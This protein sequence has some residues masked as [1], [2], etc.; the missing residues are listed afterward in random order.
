MRCL[1]PECS[2][3]ITVAEARAWISEPPSSGNAGINDPAKIFVSPGPVEIISVEHSGHAVVFAG[4]RSRIL[5]MVDGLPAPRRCGPDGRMSRRRG[6]WRGGSVSTRLKPN[7]ACQQ[8]RPPD[9]SRCGAHELLEVLKWNL[10]ATPE[11]FK[12]FSF[13]LYVP[14]RLGHGR[15]WSSTSG[16]TLTPAVLHDS[17]TIPRRRKATEAGPFPD[18]DPRHSILFILSGRSGSWRI[19]PGPGARSATRWRYWHRPSRVP[20][21]ERGKIRHARSV[22]LFRIRRSLE[23]TELET[24]APG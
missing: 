15:T 3:P 23:R 24:P 14:S 8:D 12:L 13:P 22:K 2:A 17:E 11:H 4:S 9:A 20:V 6:S 16:T 7:R 5:R 10:E 1:R 18:V 21:G 19:E